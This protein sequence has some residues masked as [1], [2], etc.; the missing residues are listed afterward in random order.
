MELDTEL[1]LSVAAQRLGY[2][3]EQLVRWGAKG[4]LTIT[5]IA[6]DWPVRCADKTKEPVNGPVHLVPK[7]LERSYNADV[8][9]VQQVIRPD[10]D[11]VLTLDDPVELLRGQLY[12]AAAEY[13][14]IRDRLGKIVGRDGEIPTFLDP[15]HKFHSR[16]L[17]IAMQ[18]WT[19]LFADGRYEKVGRGTREHILAWL[20]KNGGDLSQNAKK[21]IATLIMPTDLKGGGQPATP[22]K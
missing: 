12:V 18:A 20:A 3:V 17:A 4:E 10:D 19:E 16:H 11:V 8:I 14:R 9:R 22:T 1:D 13:R 7:D 15:A 21:Y 6:N 5:V 2:P